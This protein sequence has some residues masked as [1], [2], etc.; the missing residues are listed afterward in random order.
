[1]K[2][3]FTTLLLICLTNVAFSQSFAY[4]FE[5]VISETNSELF[6]KEIDELPAVISVE[7]RQKNE[8]KGEIL[9]S[10]DPMENRGE[11]D[12]PFSPAD[13]KALFIRYGLQPLDFRQIK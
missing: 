5:G 12:H 1:M 8:G 6:L 3:I 7:L 4:S 10:V 9:F 13:L 11:N 2:Q